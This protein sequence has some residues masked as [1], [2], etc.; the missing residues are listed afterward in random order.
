LEE[1]P[2]KEHEAMEMLEPSE[3]F[4]FDE[5]D[6]NSQDEHKE[7]DWKEV[8]WAEEAK[9]EP[10]PEQKP[11]FE[12]LELPA[13]EDHEEEQEQQFDEPE[14]HPPEVMTAET[15]KE[16]EEA[17]RAVE[18][19]PEPPIPKPSKPKKELGHDEDYELPDFD[20]SVE[21]F[22]EQET[23]TV[24]RQPSEEIVLP[25]IADMTAEDIYISTDDYHKISLHF[26]DLMKGLAKSY[27][28]LGGMTRISD[29]Q[30]V[31]FETLF[32]HINQAQDNLINID[33]R[34]FEKR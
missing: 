6:M 9:Q 5:P 20:E 14:L 12:Q 18:V 8:K 2:E 19:E 7:E 23:Q 1:M 25:E 26:S 29:E 34:L 17:E 10:A 28:A 22:D 31:H 33:R 24:I 13:P 27:N 3:G 15:H 4:K 32:S 16:P 21:V 30:K 11:N